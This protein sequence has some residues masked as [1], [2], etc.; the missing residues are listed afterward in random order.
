MR[1]VVGIEL[2]RTTFRFA[3]PVLALFGIAIGVLNSYPLVATWPNVSDVMLDVAHFLAPFVTGVAAWEALRASRRRMQAMDHTA[4]VPAPLGRLPQLLSALAWVSAAWMVVFAAVTVRAALIGL[5]GAPEF[6]TLAYSLLLPLAFVVIGMSIAN[7]VSTWIAVPIAVALAGSLYGL[8]YLDGLPAVLRSANIFT[9]FASLDGT[10]SNPTFFLGLIV[11]TFALAAV[12]A[13]ISVLQYRPYRY[14]GAMVGVVG[15]AALIAGA[16][17]AVGQRGEAGRPVPAASLPF[18]ILH[19]R[20]SKIAITALEQYRPIAGELTTAW[21]RVADLVA[22]SD[23]AF[24]ELIQQVDVDHLDAPQSFTRLYLNPASRDIVQDSIQMGLY[25]VMSC[26]REQG[27]R[28]TG[29]FGVE[30]TVV[31]ESWLQGR[32]SLSSTAWTSNPD[33]PAA[34]QWL[35]DLSNS[36]A[37]AWVAAHA[38]QIKSCSWE[39]GDFAS[40]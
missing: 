20:D 27:T 4:S 10:T 18:I 31:V 39:P 36:E 3:A 11:E 8:T 7:L 25:D 34:L 22:S 32:A 19:D 23:L 5:V 33:V 38:S 14:L 24:S 2:R 6:A 16:G 30:G 9:A 21:A 13:V 37:R 40:R 29:S 35:N 1:R 17:I 12:F 28:P 26:Y 15:V